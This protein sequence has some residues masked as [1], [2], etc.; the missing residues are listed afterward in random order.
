MVCKDRIRE[1]ESKREDEQGKRGR[2]QEQGPQ[3]GGEVARGNEKEGKRR[4]GGRPTRYELITS[5]S[6]ARC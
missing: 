3:K 4:D 1:K 5:E 2:G 6:C